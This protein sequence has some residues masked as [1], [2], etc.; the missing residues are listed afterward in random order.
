MFNAL[1]AIQFLGI[2][3]LII[4]TAYVFN[5]KPSSEQKWVILISI[6]TLI[7]VIGYSLEMCA[8]S[9]EVAYM[10]VKFIYLGKPFIILSTFFFCMKYFKVRLPKWSCA[11]ICFVQVL[12][13]VLV[14]TNEFHH[15]Y[16]S[17]QEYT[18]EGLFPHFVFSHGPAYFG[19][20]GLIMV[21]MIILITLGIKNTICSKSKVD[22]L[23]AIFLTFIVLQS[24]FCLIL[25][26][27]GITNGY[28]CT[29]L[30]YV[31]GTV[32]LFFCMVKYDILDAVGIARE[33][34]LDEFPDGLLVLDKDKKIAYINDKLISIYPKIQGTHFNRNLKVI[35]ETFENNGEIKR[36]NYIYNVSKKDLYQKGIYCGIMYMIKDVTSQKKYEI[37]LKE[38]ARI[39][40]EANKAK[41]DFLAKMSHEIR[42]PINSIM[43]M[44]EM[45]LRESTQDEIKEYAYDV[46]KS[47][48]ALLSIINAILDSSKIESGK[49]ELVPVEYKLDSFIA[50]LASLLTIKAKDKNLDFILDI[51][52][53]IPNTL[54]G[55][56]NKLHQILINI[57]NNAIKYTENGYVKLSIS[58]QVVDNKIKL[59]F[60]VE[61]T[62]I[63]I[64]ETDLPKLLHAYERIDEKRNRNIEGTGLGMNIVIGLLTLMDSEIKVE[65]TYGKGSTFS[66]EVLQDII[67]CTPI[68]KFDRDFSVVGEEIDYSP[69]F[70]APSANILVVDDNEIN[71]KIILN[72]LKQTKIKFD[73][74]ASGMECIY[75]IKSHHYDLIFMD[76][77]MPDLDG[78]KT[79]EMICADKTHMCQDVPV[80]ILTANA[81]VGE[82]ERFLGLGFND[83][84][85]KPVEP[86]KLESVIEKLLPANLI[87]SE[88]ETGS[89]E[90]NTQDET[91]S[92]PEINNID[93]DSAIK[94][95]P[96]EELMLETAQMVADGIDD[97]ILSL[98]KFNDDISNSCHDYAIKVHAVK[99]TTNMIGAIMV[100]KLALLLEMA[101]KTENYAR[102]E[103]LH[104]ILIEELRILKSDIQKAFDE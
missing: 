29:V 7:N 76:Q 97:D 33:S 6:S 1:L 86:D 52:Q 51:D 74:A 82:K 37:S 4:Q 59:F 73:E 36:D 79:F 98:C 46:K 35:E 89:Q 40:N 91:I 93:W 54:Y 39:A 48:S 14:N 31:F 42:T 71:R 32:C 68:G 58:G 30:S 27:T 67:D 2:I 77:M 41:S 47:S 8:S 81:V 17:D 84:L 83:Y 87:Y 38:Q 45:I 28:D 75:K 61:D 63:G 24:F 104:P 88:E 72:L 15:L 96:D 9:P 53:H 13:V 49:M 62:G 95:F 85:S 21:Y 20:M 5:Q 64:K 69:A 60:A 57:V 78:E 65:S 19:Y 90:I 80:V 99:S 26:Y 43:G 66:F 101:A 102:I 94:F 25:F 18:Q 16:Y 10:S 56:D 103:A 23:R 3:I 92:L 34:I 12:I 70:I 100:S 50:D 11:L 22:R 55:D 44:N